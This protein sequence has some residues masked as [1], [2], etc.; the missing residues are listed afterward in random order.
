MVNVG[1]ITFKIINKFIMIWFRLGLHNIGKNWPDFFF[2][3]IYFNMRKY[4]KFHQI[5]AVCYSWTDAI[6]N[7]NYYYL[8]TLKVYHLLTK[9]NPPTSTTLGLAFCQPSRNQ[10]GLFHY[11]TTP[12]PSL[13]LPPFGL[14]FSHSPLWYST[15]NVVWDY[16]RQRQIQLIQAIK[17]CISLCCKYQYSWQY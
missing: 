10:L 12:L 3:N 4:R 15:V 11:H 2:C 16:T 7:P 14:S 8:S 1:K 6:N 13:Y 5:R 9:Q 17:L